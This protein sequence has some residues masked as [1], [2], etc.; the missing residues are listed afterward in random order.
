MKK[1]I[2]IDLGTSTSEIAILRNGK[3][4]VLK[5]SQGKYIIPS[6]VGIN[7]NNEI[8]VGEDASEQFIL[9]PECT[10]KEVKRLMGSSKKI[11][12]GNNTYTPE[13]ISS[14]I[15][16]Y[17]KE[18]AQE[19]LKEDINSVV[20]TVPAYFTD[21]QRR[22]TVKAGELAGLKVERI[23]NEP[24]AAAL[25]YGIEHMKNEEHILV[26][27]LGGGTLDVTVLEMFDGILEVKASSGN[28]HLGGKDF[29]EALMNEI[30]DSFYKEYNID[31]R[32]DLRA[33]SRVKKE[34]EE[35]KISLSSNDEYLIELPFIAE[36]NNEPVMIQRKIS[37]KEFERLINPLIE[38][39]MKPINIALEDAKLSVEDIDVILLVGGSTRI[40]LVKEFIKNIFNIEPKCM[41]DPDL[42]VVKG[43]AIQA[44]ILNNELSK[45]S[46]ILITDVCPYTLGIETLEFMGGMPM[47]DCYSVI[48][49]RNTT[50]PTAKEEIY[51][52]VIDNQE[53]VEIKIYQ[54]DNKRASNNNL[55]GEFKLTGLPKAP[56]G[57]E[58]I[59]VK[60]VY[61]VNGIL[62][63][64]AEI[65]SKGEKAG[66]IIETTGVSM[67]EE[68]DLSKW[69]EAPKIKRYKKII[70][71]A[72]GFLSRVD[73]YEY[74]SLENSINKLKKALIKEED[75]EV[76][77]NIKSELADLLFD[78][79]GK[80]E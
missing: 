14:F 34:A 20:L 35:C 30:F 53:I 29:D 7:E 4:E 26:Y 5:N 10:I 13:E 73:E 50:I 64:D 60:F 32:C 67:N 12:L 41:V 77:K 70:E 65:V 11:T 72:E 62:K 27:D 8:I 63:V 79:E 37:R 33:K 24:T 57:Q 59:R 9:R 78:L 46:D 45:E 61:D 36:K 28:N 47:P 44:A 6:V 31:L 23:I 74:S 15:L 21:E 18:M 75:D 51:S 19:V 52:T 58:K 39:T 54:G 3:P 69:I 22:A 25:S 49:P 17:L 80:Y 2:G 48:I 55:L 40:P 43:A 76:L 71:T 16:K 66:I 1:I 68:V 42:A 38:S 56:A